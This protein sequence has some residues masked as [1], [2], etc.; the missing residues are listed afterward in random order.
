MAK[1]LIEVSIP[2]EVVMSDADLYSYIEWTIAEDWSY[3]DT[4]HDINITWES[5][6]VCDT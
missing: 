2:D 5:H 4:D 3:G 6:S 1:V